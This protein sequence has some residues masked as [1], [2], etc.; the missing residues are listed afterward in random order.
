[1]EYIH[2]KGICHR[3]LKLE[4][5][6]FDKDF[7]L[8]IADFGFAKEDSG[9]LLSRL[10]TEGYMAPEIGYKKYSGE[11]VDIFS[12]GVLLFLFYVGRPPFENTKKDNK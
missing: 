6:L 9:K 5:L 11:K 12:A 3:D 7:N 10:G 2:N 1:M 4:N 8:K